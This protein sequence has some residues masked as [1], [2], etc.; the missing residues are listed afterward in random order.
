[1]SVAGGIGAVPIEQA[2]AIPVETQ[3]VLLLGVRKGQTEV[4]YVKVLRPKVLDRQKT[5]DNERER[6]KLTGACGGESWKFRAKSNPQQLGLGAQSFSTSATQGYIMSCSR[7]KLG[8]LPYRSSR[9]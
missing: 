7:S 8:F 2:Y 4:D 6:G 1:M 3:H 5:I 9:L